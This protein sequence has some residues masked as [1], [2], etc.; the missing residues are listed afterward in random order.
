MWIETDKGELIHL[1]HYQKLEISQGHQY[2]AGVSEM[3]HNNWVL[4]G[5]TH[6]CSD[7][8]VIALCETKEE[9]DKIKGE[10]FIGIAK[11]YSITSVKYLR[12]KRG[13]HSECELLKSKDGL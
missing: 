1:R 2:I 13:K 9:C 8:A 3:I 12:E 10:V 11:E 6:N 7:G 5:L 4:H